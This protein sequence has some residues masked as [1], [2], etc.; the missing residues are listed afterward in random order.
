MKTLLQTERIRLRTA[1]SSDESNLH[2]LDNDPE[3]MRWINGGVP[4]SIEHIRNHVM[5]LFLSYDDSRPALGFWI[6]ESTPDNTFL[7]WVC[8]RAG[9]KKGQVSI[10]YRFVRSSWGKGLATEAMEALIRLGSRTEKIDRVVASTYEEN[11]ASQRV[12]E[13][14]GMKLTRRYRPSEAELQSDTS[15][16]DG[17]EPWDGDELEF[18]LTFS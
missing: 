6:V 15:V 14:L 13:K 10:G 12:L 16:S 18:E 1:E 8:M 11:I 4:V 3:V 2:A 5:P 7:G 9:K 17:G